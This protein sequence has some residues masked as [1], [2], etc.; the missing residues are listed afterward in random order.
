VL[1]LL[2]AGFESKRK[3]KGS[4][5]KATIVGENRNRKPT[6]RA[7]G[8]NRSENDWKP[9]H[10]GEVMWLRNRRKRSGEREI[11]RRIQTQDSPHHSG[12]RPNQGLTLVT[13]NFQ[14]DL[15]GNELIL[16]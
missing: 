14:M 9:L 6:R 8:K 11:H 13:E 4:D 7:E 10:R 3:L 5:K 15:E 16:S 12:V 1:A 2:K